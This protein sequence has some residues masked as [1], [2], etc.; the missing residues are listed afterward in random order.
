MESECR[1]N[2]QEVLFSLPT[3]NDALPGLSNLMADKNTV[4]MHEDHWRQFE[5]VEERFKTVIDDELTAIAAIWRNQSVS[6]GSST[7][8][9]SIHIRK[10][11]SRP[12]LISFSISDFSAL[13][14]CKHEAVAFEGRVK[15]LSGVVA[16]RV[17]RV[18]VYAE[19]WAG[20]L[21]TLG[22]TLEGK[23]TLDDGLVLRL[24]E[25]IKSKNLILCH[26]LSGKKYKTLTELQGVL[27]A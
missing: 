15:T 12:I 2:P 8:F 24:Y 26:W 23:P 3:L 11:I 14:E 19:I 1:V 20:N 25:L 10:L 21:G 16:A 5:F 27:S 4:M 17:G 7:A 18:S 13:T 22:F 9:R 6:F